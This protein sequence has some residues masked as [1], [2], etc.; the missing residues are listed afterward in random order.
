MKIRILKSSLASMLILVM[1]STLFGVS[2]AGRKTATKEKTE[3]TS[4]KERYEALKLQYDK[5]EEILNKLM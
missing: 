2:S 3:K 4:W 1:L 5:R